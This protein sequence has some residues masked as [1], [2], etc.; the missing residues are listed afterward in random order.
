MY[1]VGLTGNIASGKSTVASFFKKYGATIVSADEVARRITA[2]GQPAFQLILEHFGN[3]ILNSRG[4]IN[5]PIL[6]NL[7]FADREQRLWL[8]K[9][10]HP[11]IRNT[12]KE[13]L[14]K[15]TSCYT[16][17]EIPLLINKDD[18]PYLDRILFLLTEPKQQIDRIIERD[19][20][21]Y[22]QAKAILVAQPDNFRRLKLA[23][24]I[25]INRG[26]LTGLTM[27]IKNL[28]Q[29]YLQL[30]NKKS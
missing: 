12:I 6:R 14:A 28:H 22:Q 9:L 30:A 8:E 19:K 27:K 13:E 3:Q 5:R 21:T 29:R 17:I 4:E 16:V 2:V 24:D 10:L 26:N 25:V 18:Y 11:L 1:C 15:S 20:C 23:D 7:I